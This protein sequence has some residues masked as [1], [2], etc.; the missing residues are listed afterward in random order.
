MK[1]LILESIFCGFF[2]IILGIPVQTDIGVLSALVAYS[3]YDL[4]F[5]SLVKA[6]VALKSGK[7]P[8]KFSYSFQSWILAKIIFRIMIENDDEIANISWTD[9]LWYFVCLVAFVSTLWHMRPSASTPDLSSNNNVT[10]SKLLGLVRGEKM[11]L[12]SAIVCLIIAAIA[13]AAMPHYIGQ[14]LN[15]V[16]TGNTYPL[17][18]L[19]VATMTMALFSTFRGT[20]FTLV[21]ARV[22]VNLRSGLFESILKQEMGF[23][24]TTK[25]GD[26]SSR[27]T[28]DVQKVCDQVQLNVNYFV[29]NLISTIVTLG[30][31]FTLSWR[32]TCLALISIPF[33]AVLVHKYGEIMKEISK[34]IQ[35]KLADCNS[36]SEETLSNIRTVR[37][38]AADHMEA[39]R[40]RS[41][42]RG[43]YVTSKKSAMVSMPYMI[44]SRALP[45]LSLLLI[46][47]YGSK[48]AR[49]N[50]VDSGALISLVLYLDV[51]NGCF[52][53]MGDIYGSITA[54]L[55]A[56]DK[57]FALLEREPEFPP[58]EHPVVDI[59]P[60]GE[61]E[62]RNI[63]LSYPSR[64]EVSVLNGIS[65]NVAPG[66]VTALVGGSGQGKSSLLALLQRWYIQSSGE[67]LLD[68]YPVRRYEPD[69][70]HRVVTCVSQE[71]L[72][73]A[74]TIRE[75]ILFG[76]VNPEDYVSEDLERRTVEACKLAHAHQF[77]IGLPQGYDTE[78]GM[79]GVQLSGGQKQRIAIARAL[80][81][82]PKLLLLDEAT[83]ALDAESEQQVQLALDSMMSSSLTMIIVA[84]RLST[85]RHADVIYVVEQGRVVERGSHDELISNE[86]SAYY[87]L[88]QSQL[89]TS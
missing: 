28:Q 86:A 78:V 82:R 65:L 10:V 80:V 61:I 31:M 49:A 22:N 13:Q 46:V 1:L 27:L 4:A 15:A 12:L 69:A 47:F 39:L 66:S 84:H 40:F 20:C 35:D 44:L 38:F 63:F 36:A 16:Q 23:F 79:R 26:L 58:T 83:S 81:R 3:L 8:A 48:L 37:S 67:V 51:L 43:V 14:S 2:A 52:S 32:L 70:Y 53:A 19:L 74:R 62:F 33:T 85:V 71:P 72:L 25:T 64:P 29:R 76:F 41:L 55:G 57:V 42:L 56:A 75:N 6:A 5:L 11:L 50:V 9:E 77:I 89:G 18:A 60:R 21:G 17:W 73:F 68:G 87:K 88:V 59:D 7:I 54:A 34:E 30:F 45:Y 24:D